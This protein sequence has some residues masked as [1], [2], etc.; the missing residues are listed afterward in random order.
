MLLAWQ[1]LSVFFALGRQLPWKKFDHPPPKPPHLYAD[2]M[3]VE[4]EPPPLFS[5]DLAADRS[6]IPKHSSLI[7]SLA[8]R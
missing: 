5:R 3:S 2:F 4:F 1:K 7:S 8:Q 6:S